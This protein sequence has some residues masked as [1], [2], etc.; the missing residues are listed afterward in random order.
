MSDSSL[1]H[2]LRELNLKNAMLSFFKFILTCM[3]VKSCVE[4][5]ASLLKATGFREYGKYQAA[6]AVKDE[7]TSAASLLDLLGDLGQIWGSCD[8]AMW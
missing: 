7:R 2:P 5:V 6:Y 1:V 3:Q 4:C 8:L